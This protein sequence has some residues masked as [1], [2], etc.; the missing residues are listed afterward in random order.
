MR[1]NRIEK[2]KTGRVGC[3]AA[4]TV[5]VAGGGYSREDMAAIRRI[6]KA[7]ACQGDTHKIVGKAAAERVKA[8]GGTVYGEQTLEHLCKHP[9]LQC[10]YEY[11]RRSWRYYQ[12]LSA[13]GT[14]IQKVA[15]DLCWSHM[16]QLSRLLD[17][18]DLAKVAP[19]ILSLA[20]V[21]QKSKWTATH[22]SR[23]VSAA[24]RP[25]PVPDSPS[26][27][28][29]TDYCRLLGKVAKGMEAAVNEFRTSGLPKTAEVDSHVNRLGANYASL[30]EQVA[31]HGHRREIESAV[32]TVVVR[33]RDAVSAKLDTEDRA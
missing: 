24:L 7:L 31:R 13:L 21:A 15:P 9:D 12:L 5:P 10:D 8:K 18:G 28:N 19:E 29:K 20:N 11:L 17:D 33:L 26:P 32:R 16:Y 30:V 25:T 4:K 6:N 27:G 1:R 14:K 23:E 22:L 3:P 2:Q